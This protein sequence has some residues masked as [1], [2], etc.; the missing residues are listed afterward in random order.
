MLYFI[1]FLLLT[2]GSTVKSHFD[3]SS[4]FAQ[5]MLQGS[6]V[7]LKCKLSYSQLLATGFASHTGVEH[8]EHPGIPA[9]HRDEPG[10]GLGSS[11]K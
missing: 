10:L 9:H 1:I 11:E 4:L 6:I 3:V 2:V 5:T 7:V 8:W